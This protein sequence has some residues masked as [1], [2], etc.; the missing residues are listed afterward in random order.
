MYGGW[1]DGHYGVISSFLL[2][3]NQRTNRYVL[4]GGTSL[5]LC[6]GLDRFS[7][8]IDLDA[9]PKAPVIFSIV[10]L[11]CQAN[12]YVF[13]VEED[14]DM[15]KRASIHYGG[16]KPLKVEVSYRDKNI[17]EDK[18][19]YVNNILVYNIVN[20]AIMKLGVYNGRGRLRDLYDVVFIFRN[21][22]KV[23]PQAVVMMLKNVLMYKGIEYF[24]YVVKTQKDDLIDVDKLASDF[25][26]L[27][28]Y[29]GLEG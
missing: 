5:M 4:K 9:L 10:V 1:R 21:Y 14:T 15:V 12:G 29:L 16:M 19:G 25:L 22:G 7:E 13:C 27:L 17:T 8:D 18:Y 20:L 23:M 6:Y 24:D 11:F 2:F 26:D 28:V 3:L